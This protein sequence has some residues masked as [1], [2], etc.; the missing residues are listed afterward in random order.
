MKVTEKCVLNS[1]SSSP[2]STPLRPPEDLKSNIL[3]A[4]AEAAASKVRME[5]MNQLLIIVW[6]NFLFGVY[7]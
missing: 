1:T 3:K 5:K 6:V 4:Q 7:L 2:V